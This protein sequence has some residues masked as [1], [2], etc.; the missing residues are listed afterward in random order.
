MKEESDSE[1]QVNEPTSATGN[2][3][4]NHLFFMVS[5]RFYFLVS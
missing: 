1:G 3:K 5:L 2:N 4:W